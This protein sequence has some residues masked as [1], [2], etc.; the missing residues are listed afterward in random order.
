MRQI[1]P[2]AFLTF[3]TATL[4]ATSI[5]FKVSYMQFE[6]QHMRFHYSCFAIHQD[7]DCQSEFRTKIFWSDFA[8]ATDIVVDFTKSLLG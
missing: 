7:Y 2:V 3:L 5:T 8:S 1:R 4:P 6:F